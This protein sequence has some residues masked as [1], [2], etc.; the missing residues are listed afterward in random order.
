MATTQRQWRQLADGY[1]AFALRV[2]NIFQARLP[3]A[4]D[5]D[6]RASVHWRDGAIRAL[7]DYIE[8]AADAASATEQTLS[9]AL[10]CA[11]DA[12]VTFATTGRLEFKSLADSILADITHIAVPQA[13]LAPAARLMQ[14]SGFLGSF[15]AL[16]G[17][18]HQGGVV[19]EPLP[20]RLADPSVFLGAPRYHSGGLVGM[21]R[22]QPDEVPIIARRGEEV[23]TR[24]DPRHRAN[25]H[26]GGRTIQVSMTVVTRDA[27]SFRASQGQITA[28][29]ALALRRAERNL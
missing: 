1:E 24:D 8:A 11:E 9:R 6:L 26:R 18:A 5:A 12:L 17:L 16:F 27:D 21:P 13:I 19:G 23:L 14:G 15:G 22:L 29:L 3:A 4:R 25:D 2:E 10:R 20:A 7:R 28:E